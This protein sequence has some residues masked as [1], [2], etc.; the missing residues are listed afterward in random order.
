[1]VRAT[2]VPDRKPPLALRPPGSPTDHDERLFDAW[3]H[4]DRIAGD[5]LARRYS[6]TLRSFFRPRLPP[7]EV[8]D[9]TQRVLLNTIA[10]PQRFRG[11][12]SLS[13][14]V[15][16]V[17]RKALAERH[18]KFWRNLEDPHFVDDFPVSDAPVSEIVAHCEGAARLEA[19]IASLSPHH[20]R[21]LELHLAGIGHHETAAKLGINRNTSR[22]RLVR[23][24]EEVRRQLELDGVE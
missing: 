3:R 9:L 19:I 7:Q 8:E 22:S 18:R 16:S 1:M 2:A 4:G 12:S 5:K 15:A 17:A 21:V 24:I 10:Q 6:S 11:A 20:A 14:Y 23:A 13:T